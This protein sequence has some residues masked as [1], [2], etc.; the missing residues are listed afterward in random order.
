MGRV[1]ISKVKGHAEEDLVRR[2][3]VRELDRDG[4]NR[5]D[6]A[7]DFGRRRVGPHVTDARRNLSGVCGRWY[8]VVKVL[9]RLFI[10][11]SRAV[12]NDDGS[13]G[14]ALRLLVFRGSS[15]ET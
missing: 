14:T 13:A 11:I 1:C 6:D 2:G 7:G 12:V 3:Q 10:A 5:A 8:S 15:Q 4:K 9:H